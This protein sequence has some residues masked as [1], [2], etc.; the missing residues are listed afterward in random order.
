MYLMI[1]GNRID[2]LHREK[3]EW[4]WAPIDK[5]TPGGGMWM[6]R[7]QLKNSVVPTDR[8][9]IPEGADLDDPEWYKQDKLVFDEA[10]ISERHL[11]I[12]KHLSNGGPIISDEL[13]KAFLEAKLIDFGASYREQA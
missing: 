1:V 8:W 2:S 4:L 3:T 6:R 9:V 7:Y 13:H 5:V 11:W 10:K 12:E